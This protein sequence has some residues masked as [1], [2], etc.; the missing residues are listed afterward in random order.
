MFTDWETLDLRARGLN[1][2][3]SDDVVHEWTRLEGNGASTC[4]AR[5]N[6]DIR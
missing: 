6:V 1:T 5:S 2:R 4:E 3:Q